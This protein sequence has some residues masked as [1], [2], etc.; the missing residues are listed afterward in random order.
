MACYVTWQVVRIFSV[1][2][3][4]LSKIFLSIALYSNSKE[5]HHFARFVKICETAA[6]LESK[7][8]KKRRYNEVRDINDDIIWCA[9][10]IANFSG[11]YFYCPSSNCDRMLLRCSI[12]RW[13]HARVT[14]FCSTYSRFAICHHMKETT[15]HAKKET[16]KIQFNSI[17]EC[18]SF[19]ARLS[20]CFCTLYFTTVST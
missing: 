10:S 7:R 18:S 1:T 20:S 11:V 2:S 16:R 17:C 14:P 3:F 4:A 19:T 8:K 15:W 6:G 12:T 5:S 13:Q 9:K